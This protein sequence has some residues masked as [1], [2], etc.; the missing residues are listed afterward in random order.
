MG[1]A[2][3]SVDKE[4]W[5]RLGLLVGNTKRAALIRT[6]IDWYLRKPGAKL[7]ARPPEE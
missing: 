2:L 6:F 1:R 4:D 7:P 3:F 5:K